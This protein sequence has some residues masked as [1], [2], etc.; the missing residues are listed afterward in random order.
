MN[1]RD[2]QFLR[3][4]RDHRHRYQERFYEARSKEF[5]AAHEQGINLSAWLMAGTA[6]AA[7]L[8][9]LDAAN[10]R[11]WWAVIGAALPAL[12]SALAAYEKLYGFDQTAKIYSDAAVSLQLARASAPDVGAHRTE[13]SYR[14]AL[15]AYVSQVEAIFHR[16]QGQWGQLVTE[17]KLVDAVPD[18]DKLEE[19]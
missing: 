5:D 1:A 6:V 15:S 17:L 14:Q 4:Y 11:P 12:S 8:A 10:L 7:A 19:S 9:G 2:Q 16:E 13:A 3:L 18:E